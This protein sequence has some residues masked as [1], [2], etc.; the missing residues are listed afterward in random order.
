MADA[1][2]KAR[3]A[4]SK[5]LAANEAHRAREGEVLEVQRPF[6]A[7][8]CDCCAGCAVVLE[9]MVSLLKVNMGSGNLA[10]PVCGRP[11]I[12]ARLK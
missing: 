8:R 12:P 3:P 11:A 7:G 6:R 2:P 5:A 10:D 4:V 9:G 1:L